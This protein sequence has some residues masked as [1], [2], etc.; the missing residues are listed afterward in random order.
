MVVPAKAGGDPMLNNQQYRNMVD[1]I[2]ERCPGHWNGRRKQLTMGNNNPFNFIL[3]FP[4]GDERQGMQIIYR[5]RDLYILGY[6]TIAGTSYVTHDQLA[7][8]AGATDLGFNGDYA[9]LGWN[10][11][12]LAVNNGGPVVS[13]PE[14]DTALYRAYDGQ[15]AAGDLCIMAIALAEAVRFKNVERAVRGGDPITT[16]MVDWNQQIV[17]GEATLL[18]G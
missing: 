13:V 5:T 8:V 6:V 12:G 3:Q 16:N 9:T 10:R 11:Q 1:D 15:A 4:N 17:S 14:L 2:I 18:S 7:N